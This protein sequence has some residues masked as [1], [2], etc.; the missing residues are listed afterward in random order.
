MF[1]CENGSAC[2][3]L[4]AFECPYFANTGECFYGDQCRNSHVRNAA[5]MRKGMSGPSSPAAEAED[6]QVGDM[7]TEVYGPSRDSANTCEESHAFTQQ[8]DYLPL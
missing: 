3:E 8:A 1:Y 2:A 6:D 7:T 5:K 4:H